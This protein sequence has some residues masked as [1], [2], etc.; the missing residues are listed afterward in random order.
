MDGHDNIYF[1]EG[2]SYYKESLYVVLLQQTENNNYI[3]GKSKR[4]MD[5]T[6][7]IGNRH[8]C[9]QKYLD[10]DSDTNSSSEPKIKKQQDKEENQ[11]YSSIYVQD[12]NEFKYI[13]Y[14]IQ[15][16]KYECERW[17]VPAQQMDLLK[18]RCLT[19]YPNIEKDNNKDGSMHLLFAFCGPP[20]KLCWLHAICLFQIPNYDNKDQTSSETKNEIVFIPIHDFTP[21]KFSGNSSK[22]SVTY[23]R[24][25][26]QL[27]IVVEGLTYLVGS[28]TDIKTWLKKIVQQRIENPQATTFQNDGWFVHQLGYPQ[29]PKKI[30]QQVETYYAEGFCEYLN[31]PN[32]LAAIDGSSVVSLFYIG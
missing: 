5:F 26:D 9:V 11:K 1:V 29:I 27:L 23:I 12:I 31:E 6:A 25:L 24:S 2:T 16:N 7:G 17:A 18:L 14:Q 3:Y 4:V 28:N 22:Y 8:W 10:A 15:A 21:G 13:R 19:A 32:T 20:P 30:S